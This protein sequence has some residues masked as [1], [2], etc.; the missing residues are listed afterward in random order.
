MKLLPQVYAKKTSL[1][2]KVQATLHMTHYLVHPLMLTLALF[3]L[4]VLLTFKLPA[5][6]EFFWLFAFFMAVATF[7]PSTLYLTSQRLAYKDWK[8]RIIILPLLVTIGVGLAVSNSLAVL[9]ALTGRK[10]DFVRTPKNGDRL[11]K[12]YRVKV[13]WVTF[14]EILVGLYCLLSFT[15]YFQA[16]KYLVGPFL[17]IYSIGF[18][19]IGIMTLVHSFR[20]S[21]VE[22]A[23]APSE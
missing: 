3:S 14:F 4:P 21:K 20:V 16:K 12:M 9:Q 8:S 6:Q 7:A 1:F 2:K 18:L 23:L 22:P 19:F 5:S 10:S 17:G 11:K 13:P 15:F